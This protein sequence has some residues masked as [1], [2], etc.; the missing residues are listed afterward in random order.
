MKKILFIAVLIIAIQILPGCQLVSNPQNQSHPQNQSQTEELCYFPTTYSS[1]EEFLTWLESQK[2]FDEK[3]QNLFATDKVR[4]KPQKI[5]EG[6]KLDS[7][8]AQIN[9]VEY[10]Y[11]K[12]DEEVYF[13]FSYQTIHYFDITEKSKS[14]TFEQT[15]HGHDKKITKNNID[16]YIMYPKT[17]NDD[18]LRGQII[19]NIDNYQCAIYTAGIESYDDSIFEYCEFEKVPLK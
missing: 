12:I 3:Y 11:K 9:L 18:V 2:K 17:V 10:S 8:S 15:L 14:Q 4:F 19:W 5:P 1:E 13:K 6:Y 16:Y 7:I